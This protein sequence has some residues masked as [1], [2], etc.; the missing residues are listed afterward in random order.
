MLPREEIKLH[1]CYKTPSRDLKAGLLPP[2]PCGVTQSVRE[3]DD[4][5]APR[6][7]LGVEGSVYK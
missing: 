2:F 3:W 5:T 7:P 1:Y 6:R 4:V